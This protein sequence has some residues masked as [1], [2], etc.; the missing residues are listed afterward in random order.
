MKKFNSEYFAER[1]LIKQKIYTLSVRKAAKEIGI[2]ASNL[3]RLNNSKFIPDVNTFN[4]CC[5]WMGLPMEIFFIKQ[6]PNELNK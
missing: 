3:C 2:S 4:S 6:A 5:D 1:L